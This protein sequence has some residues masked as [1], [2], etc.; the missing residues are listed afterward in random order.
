MRR[1]PLNENSIK[2]SK[3]VILV[4]FHQAL[5]AHILI[6]HLEQNGIQAFLTNEVLTDLIP[7]SA[8]GYIIRVFSADIPRANE[9]LK[10]FYE[11]ESLEEEF[12]DADHEDIAYEELKYKRAQKRMVYN[13]YFIP[14]I[15]LMI[16]IFLFVNGI[17]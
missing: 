9:V 5:K 12:Y 2:N 11:Q 4:R 10:V 13:V 3:Q 6:N 15:I 1:H 16:L 8:G 14:L 17:L 7:T